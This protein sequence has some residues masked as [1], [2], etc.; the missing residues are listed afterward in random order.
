MNFQFQAMLTGYTRCQKRALADVRKRGRNKKSANQ[1][2]HRRVD[3]ESELKARNWILQSFPNLWHEIVTKFSGQS[4]TGGDQKETFGRRKWTAEGRCHEV[5]W[6]HGAAAGKS[7]SVGHRPGHGKD[8][9]DW[10]GRV[11]TTQSFPWLLPACP[12][13]NCFLVSLHD[14]KYVYIA[15][16]YL[17]VLRKVTSDPRLSACCT[18]GVLEREFRFTEKAINAAAFQIPPLSLD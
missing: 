7:S 9:V 13:L 15:C 8:F 1:C 3:L 18:D 17:G 14:N 4:G 12:S 2:R 11:A 16:M 5:G 6:C 10:L